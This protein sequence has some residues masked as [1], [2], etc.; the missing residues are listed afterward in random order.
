MIWLRKTR[1][2]LGLYDAKVDGDSIDEEIFKIKKNEYKASIAEI[3]SQIR[4]LGDGNP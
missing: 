2:S 4:T 3:K 1:G